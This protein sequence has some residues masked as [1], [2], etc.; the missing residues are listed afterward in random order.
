M[1][2]GGYL[3]FLFHKIVNDDWC[4]FFFKGLI[5]FI[6]KL[7]GPGLLVFVGVIITASIS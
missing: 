5:K 2:L 4:Y 3:L 6:H 1:N 7:G